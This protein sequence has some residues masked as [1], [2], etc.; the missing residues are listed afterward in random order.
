VTG[1]YRRYYRCYIDAIL[2][3]MATVVQP[4][5]ERLLEAAAELLTTKGELSTRAVCEA[6]G[7]GAPTLYHHFGDKEG[8]IEAAVER[9][10]ESNLARKR[11]RRPTA[12]PVDDVRRGWDEHVD[13]ARRQPA[14]Y[15]LMYAVAD[16]RSA[17]TQPMREARAILSR[18]IHRIAEAGRLRVEPDLAAEVI[19]TAV[20][21]V[22]GQVS[23][24]QPL[25]N[26]GAVNDLI[27]EAVLGA[28]FAAP[29]ADG[30]AAVGESGAARHALAL[31]ELARSGASGLSPAEAALLDEWLRRIVA[32]NRREKDR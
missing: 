23:S 21:G 24:K 11:A 29:E 1:V 5:R 2:A 15:R 27:R 25:P 20:R 3:E 10:Y 14:F 26:T 8:L 32:A 4:P 28:L 17:P 31:A 7:V 30:A 13:F 6:A 19:H 9:A 22:G 16:A 18:E 12:D